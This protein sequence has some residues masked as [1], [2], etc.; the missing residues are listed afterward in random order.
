MRNR[1]QRQPYLVLWALAVA[2]GWMEAAVV[3]YLREISLREVNYVAGFQFPL[4]SIPAPLLSVEVVREAC[5]LVV[6]GAVGWLV[7]RRRADRIG[8]FLLLFGLWDLTYY[9]VLRLVLGWPD[10]PMRWD[11][12][13]LIPLP[14]VAP[15]W[16]PA[17][18]AGI[19]VVAG[20]YL[21]WTAGR[22][23]SYG[24]KDIGIL[25][26][27]VLLILAAF[28]ADW[29]FALDQRVPEHFALWQFWVGVLL[30]TS[31]FVR[32]E[33]RTATV[34]G[35]ASGASGIGCN[36]GEGTAPVMS[37]AERGRQKRDRCDSAA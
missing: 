12:L 37:A 31:W 34:A 30:G 20:S 10:T 13:F 18:I 27:S 23:R 3:I 9:G 15:V 26:V 16:A 6:L 22:P 2:F 32:V 1:Q 14:W 28:M 8:A 7:G 21:F 5:S 25:L 4:V 17:T 24:W 11:L 33:R 19:F 29:K 35:R 36:P